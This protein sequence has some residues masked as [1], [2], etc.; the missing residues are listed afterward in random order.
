MRTATRSM[1]EIRF[2]I[3][4]LYEWVSIPVFRELS[5][6]EESAMEPVP[7]PGQVLCILLTHLNSPDKIL[8]S[9][10]L[11]S[12]GLSLPHQT[13]GQAFLSRVLIL[14][15]HSLFTV[16][17]PGQVSI[18]FL[19]FL[20]LFFRV[21]GFFCQSFPCSFHLYEVLLKTSWGNEDTIC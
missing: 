10:S 13:P 2:C 20:L 12:S 17:L 7:S 15:S 16:R 6:I 14:I 1:E 5:S 19:T 21:N 11:S 3:E 18:N 8:S 9:R 4:F